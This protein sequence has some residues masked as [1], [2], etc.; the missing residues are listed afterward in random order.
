MKITKSVKI[1]FLIIILLAAF[2]RIYKLSEVPPSLNWDEA[3]NGYN[4]WTI[5]NYG[6]DEWGEF[7]PLTFT[8]FRDDRHP[9]L[10]YS[11][12][13]IVKILGLSEFST[14]LPIAL[15]GVFCVAVIF[16]L[17]RVM[18]KSNLVGLLAAL[19][20]AISPYHIYFSHYSQESNTALF[21][22]LVGLL[23]FYLGINGRPKLL[24]FSA[25]GFGLSL[26]GYHSAKI[27]VPPVMLLLLV[28]YFKQL[29]GNKKY[30]LISLLVFS[31]F[32]IVLFYNPRLLGLARI[33]QTSFS[34]EQLQQTDFYKKTGSEKLGLLNIALNQYPYF[35]KYDYLF[36]NGGPSSK[37]STQHY[38]LFHMIDLPFL[39][40]GALFL[41]IKRSKAGIVLLFW[42]LL[43][44]MPSSLVNEAPHPTRAM[45]MMGSWQLIIG[46]GIYWVYQFLQRWKVRFVY[47]SIIL[48]VLTVS[49]YK[50]Y[51]I[52]INYYPKRYAIDWQYGMKQIV[53]H[54]E[55]Y[56]NY[57]SVYMT[58]VRSQPYIFFLF[59]LQQPLPE[60]LNNVNYTDS[61]ANNY[62][63]N[64][65]SSFGKYHFGD[66]DPIE[67]KP[68]PGVLYILTTSQYDGLKYKDKFAIRKIVRFPDKAVAFYLVSA[69]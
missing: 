14:R 33:G 59:Y 55:N 61:K 2:L 41:L 8:A 40:L 49:L 15:Y 37:L 48:V 17:A 31:F 32:I 69:I 60:L 34:S 46:I 28:L 44:P 27:V 65:I 47:I 12:A 51:D 22:F 3:D 42:A 29:L 1:A 9:V 24:I 62:K 10:I 5:A 52:Y 56:P 20:L 50:F 16:F 35:F 18:F 23:F 63:Y 21:F 57:S 39:I 58:D 38:G 54:V 4:A 36:I 13:G 66:W 53:E 68:D 64:T 26:F 11:T 45:F 19:V 25:I 67:S 6:R 7:F 43:A 30:F